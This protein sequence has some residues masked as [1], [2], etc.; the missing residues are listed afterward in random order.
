MLDSSGQDTIRVGGTLQV[1]LIL[2][3]SSYYLYDLN[4]PITVQY[5]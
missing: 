1:T 4:V 3:A 5:N 2:N